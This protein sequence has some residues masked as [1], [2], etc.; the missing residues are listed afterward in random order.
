[1][2]ATVEGYCDFNRSSF[3]I[4]LLGDI[5]YLLSAIAVDVMAK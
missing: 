2:L 4:V 3:T 5:E 1:M